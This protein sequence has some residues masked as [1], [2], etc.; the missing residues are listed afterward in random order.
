MPA[1]GSPLPDARHPAQTVVGGQR[2]DEVD[3]RHRG[4]AVDAIIAES[5]RADDRIGA[6][7][8]E[9]AVGA[10]CYFPLTNNGGTRNS[11]T[12]LHSQ[13]LTEDKNTP[14]LLGQGD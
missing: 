5:G 14:H 6:A 8:S 4:L 12:L 2:L 1:I 9:V 11:G 10:R 3:V 13:L 7:V